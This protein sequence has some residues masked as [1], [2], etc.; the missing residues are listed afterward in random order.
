MTSAQSGAKP[1]GMDSPYGHMSHV[2]NPELA[3]PG[4][5]NESVPGEPAEANI[6]YKL[7]IARNDG[8]DR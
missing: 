2:S 1:K 5:E 4:T 8:A 3:G 6:L 7:N